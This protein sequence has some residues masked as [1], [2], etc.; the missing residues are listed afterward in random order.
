RYINPIML[1]GK[2]LGLRGSLEQHLR[3]KNPKA[4]E[5]HR[6][7]TAL[8]DEIL[9][10]GLIKP[11][12]VY[13][14]FAVDARGDRMDLYDSPSATTPLAGF[15]FPRQTSGERLCLAD[16]VRPAS[17]STN[18]AGRDYAA[19][20]VVTCGA[21]IR[22]LS[23]QYRDAGEYLKSHALQSIAIEAAEG[24]A[25]LLHD[26]LRRMWGIGDPQGMTIREKFQGKYRGIRVSFGYP[27]CPNL[28]DQTILF[29]LLDPQRHAGV[30]LTEGFMMEPEATV[31]ALVFHHPAARYFSVGQA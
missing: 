2:H 20:F 17:A 26:R 5:L 23:D 22:E 21:G 14:F 24:F 11:K 6:R 18:G 16:F 15:N 28:E 30:T 3:D 25:E 12:A 8:Q 4:I 13:K 19:M 31:S 27:A 9:Q 1:Y 7:V 29:K 10:K